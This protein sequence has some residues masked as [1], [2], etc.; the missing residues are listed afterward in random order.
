[1]LVL[2]A[3]VPLVA[4]SLPT[5][6]VEATTRAVVFSANPVK[7]SAYTLLNF[8]LVLPIVTVSVDTPSPCN[9]GIILFAKILKG[10]FMLPKPSLV[11][12]II[13]VPTSLAITA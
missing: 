1:M 3:T 8:W 7:L 13:N 2:T 9:P 5:L 11:L 4:L 12:N 6:F 10:F